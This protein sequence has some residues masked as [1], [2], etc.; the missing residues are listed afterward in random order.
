MSAAVALMFAVI[1]AADVSLV[2]DAPA[3]CTGSS[4]IAEEVEHLIGRPV[5]FGE[6]AAIRATA[7]VRAGWTAEV[8]VTSAQGTHRRTLSAPTC[9]ELASAMALILSLAIDD[10]AAAQARRV[11]TSV[12]PVVEPPLIGP[13]VALRGRSLGALALG[14][15]IFTDVGSLPYPAIGLG[16]SASW[17]PIEELSF[18]TGGTIFI[19][20]RALVRSSPEAGGALSFQALRARGCFHA[21]PL[22]EALFAGCAGAE[23]AWLTARGFGIANPRRDTTRWLAPFAALT[24]SYPFADRVTLGANLELLF[25]SVRPIFVLDGIAELHRTPAVL[26]RMGL[27]AEVHFP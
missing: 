16:A 19:R 21:P 24:A 1:S 3:E 18:G 7:I 25:P 4:T 12:E 20:Q 11:I 6:P 13:P 23:L 17:R 5:T 27:I 10:R 9:G 15:S 22:A 8:A 26:A 14:A 2:W